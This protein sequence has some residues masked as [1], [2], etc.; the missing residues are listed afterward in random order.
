[1]EKGQARWKNERY[2]GLQYLSYI[3]VSILTRHF[4][5]LATCLHESHSQ[6]QLIWSLINY[7][8]I[9][10]SGPIGSRIPVSHK[11]GSC[12]EKSIARLQMAGDSTTATERSVSSNPASTEAQE[13][14]T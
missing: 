2:E 9:R 14:R 7:L 12:V 10:T 3:K 6:S 1:M 11:L 4:F 8:L 5:N 13:T